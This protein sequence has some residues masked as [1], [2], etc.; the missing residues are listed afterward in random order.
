MEAVRFSYLGAG[1]QNDS[2][3]P[4]GQQFVC[5]CLCYLPKS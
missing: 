2:S 1:D 3:A 4:S 5:V